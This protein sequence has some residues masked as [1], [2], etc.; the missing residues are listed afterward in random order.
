M[1]RTNRSGACRSMAPLVIWSW[2]WTASRDMA[3]PT[4][5]RGTTTRPM[6]VRIVA[7]A[8]RDLRPFSL[9]TYRLWTGK[10]TVASTAAQNTGMRKA[11]M[12][13]RNATV[14]S[15]TRT[16]KAPFWIAVPRAV[17]VEAPRRGGIRSDD[18][19]GCAA[20]ERILGLS[21]R[22]RLRHDHPG[23]VGEPNELGHGP[24]LHL[25]HDPCAVNLDRLLS[26]A[27]LARDLLV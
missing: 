18:R 13:A 16:R 4:R 21:W 6:I 26:D 25:L 7:R 3:R 20:T 19:S 5:E 14:V 1:P 15:A 12:S 23:A 2:S 11:A 8:A 9:L 10:N 22:S 24:G 27:E 17:N